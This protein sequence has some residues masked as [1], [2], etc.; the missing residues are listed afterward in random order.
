MVA[1]LTSKGQITLPVGLRRQLGLK[2]GDR[3]DFVT[4]LDGTV[5]VRPVRNALLELAGMAKP[6]DGRRRS[7]R[8][9]EAAISAGRSAAG[10]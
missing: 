2:S 1:T 8:E 7:L 6:I 3:V 9:M 10:K 5:T 4:G